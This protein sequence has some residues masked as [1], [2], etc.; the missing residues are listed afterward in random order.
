MVDLG[1]DLDFDLCA[2][3]NARKSWNADFRRLSLDSAQVPNGSLC[4]SSPPDNV[5]FGAL[6]WRQAAPLHR[7][8][9]N[10]G[11]MGACLG[12]EKVTSRKRAGFLLRFVSFSRTE[13]R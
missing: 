1:P 10:K 4:V 2:F 7:V 5:S 3:T 12:Y 13:F 9:V 6:W 8:C 11:Y